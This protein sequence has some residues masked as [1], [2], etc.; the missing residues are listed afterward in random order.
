MKKLVLLLFLLFFSASLSSAISSELKESYS[1]GETI[2]TKVQGNI[3]EPIQPSQVE[4]K[5]GHVAVAFEYDLKRLG[6]TYYLYAVLPPLEN[7]YTLVIKDISTSVAGSAQ[8]VDFTHNFSTAGPI[9]DYSVSPGLVISSGKFDIDVTLNENSPLSINVDFPSEKE[10][11]LSPGINKIS[12]DVSASPSG[13]MEINVG[14]Y[15]IPLMVVKQ[16]TP[17]LNQE[18]LLFV[19]PIF[20]A[21]LLKGQTQTYNV[22]IVNHGNSTIEGLMFEYDGQKLLVEPP[23]FSNIS[24]NET[25][26]INITILGV[27]SN[28]SE[29]ILAKTPLSIFEFPLEVS[30][31]ESEEEVKGPSEPSAGYYCLELGGKICSASEACSIGTVSTLDSVNCCVGLCLA[32]EESANSWVGYVIGLLLLGLLVF[33]IAKYRKSSPKQI[34][35]PKISEALKVK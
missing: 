5:R 26:E 34:Q 21:S 25:V 13:V 20:Q 8:K 31:V 11:T 12:F 17:Q 7:N 23:V 35:T 1:P 14:K 2:I 16:E 18:S 22:K 32:E 6:D 28:L 33:I 9:I 24:S 4:L 3:L 10:V 30:I 27:E 19:P 15:S 29:I